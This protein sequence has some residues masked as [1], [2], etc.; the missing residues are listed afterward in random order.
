MTI[1][2]LEDWYL[3]VFNW[4][5]CG[6]SSLC[7]QIAVNTEHI[8]MMTSSNWNIFRVTGHLCGELTVTNEFPAQRP[9]TRSFDVFFD[10][11]LNKRL[12]KHLWGQWLET[13][14]RPL[15]RHSNESAKICYECVLASASSDYLHKWH[16]RSPKRKPLT[17]AE[18]PEW[19]NTPPSV[20]P[21]D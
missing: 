7:Y 20:S 14:S 12:S 19:Y 8:S 15:W 13:L 17:A 9:M 2:L 5:Q 16:G 4:H 11:H 3:L 18:L 1:F 6:I 10:R 21:F